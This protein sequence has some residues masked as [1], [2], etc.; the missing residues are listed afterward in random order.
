MPRNR[1][2]FV[3]DEPLV[4]HGLRRALRAMGEEWEMSFV[5]SGEEALEVLAREPFDA[6]ITD[7][8]MPRMNGAQLLEKV[9]LRHPAVVRIVLSGQSSREEVLRSIGPT[10]QYLSKPCDP[11]ELR[12]RLTQAFAMRD[13]LQNP[14]I[15][16]VV[17]GL[18]S[19]PSL[20]ALY[21]EVLA[22]IQAE[23]ASLNRIA[24]V[25]AKDAGMTAKILQVANS[26][27]MGIRYNVSSPVQA[28]SLIGIE[29]V[30]SLVL[31]VHVFSQFE[32][33][34]GIT[35]FW[36]GLWQHSM[37]VACLAQRIAVC[38][39]SPK[40][41]VDESFTAGL[42]HDIGKLV[43]LARLPKEYAA[44]VAGLARNPVPLPDAEQQVFGCTHADLG[45]YLL[46]IWGHPHP[47]IQAVAYHDRPAESAD[48]KFSSLT[49][50][51]VADALISAGNSSLIIQ[52]TQLDESYLSVLG[53]SARESIWRELHAE[54]AK[55]VAD[56]VT[57]K[58]ASAQE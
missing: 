18:H 10:H 48:R 45:A 42:L 21:Q 1:L 20:P 17:S 29:M 54:C 22:E 25:I 39:K 24:T 34:E 23:D 37:S 40:P 35:S 50:V 33:H 58:A 2:L 46:S 12:L 19:V 53:L 28:V 5:E 3:D 56:A 47:L 27:F 44:I 57:G 9:K 14:A 6:V 15:P 4:L 7:M 38:E 49:A 8:R 32:G 16:A 55:Q 13:R 26:A 31:F 30:R 36:T 52:D 11:Q 51:H 43:L 41:L